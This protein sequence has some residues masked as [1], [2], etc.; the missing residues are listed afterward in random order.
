MLSARKT[1]QLVIEREF[2]FLEFCSIEFDVLACDS[3][4]LADAGWISGESLAGGRQA[5]ANFR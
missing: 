3:L 4:A 1:R 5:Y 2:V